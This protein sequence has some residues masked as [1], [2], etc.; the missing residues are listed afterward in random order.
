[1]LPPTVTNLFHDFGPGV[2]GLILLISSLYRGV[3][4]SL[5]AVPGAAL[6]LLGPRLGL[7]AIGPVEAPLAGMASGA[8]LLVLGLLFGGSRH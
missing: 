5:F 7:P 1:M 2:A 3:K 4:M 8:A 6:G